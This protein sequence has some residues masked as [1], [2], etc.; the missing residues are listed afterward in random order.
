MKIKIKCTNHPSKFEPGLMQS[1]LIFVQWPSFSL[2]Q[3]SLFP[4]LLLFYPH[5]SQFYFSTCCS[6]HSFWLIYE[7]TFK[8]FTTLLSFQN[9]LQS[10]FQLT[11]VAIIHSP[12]WSVQIPTRYT[13][14]WHRWCT[15]KY[16]L[17]VLFDFTSCLLCTLQ[18]SCA[19]GCVFSQVCSVTKFPLSHS[20]PSVVL[21][22]VFPLNS[23]GIFIKLLKHRLTPDPLQ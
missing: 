6:G 3:E 15:D 2:S 4:F 23:L 16:L 12:N 5:P 21:N 19:F 1:A 9:V 7:F 18:A 10:C 14:K 17:S 8:F 22:N 20:H 11:R 13:Q